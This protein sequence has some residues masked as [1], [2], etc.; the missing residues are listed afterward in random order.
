MNPVSVQNATHTHPEVAMWQWAQESRAWERT[1][2]L[3]ATHAASTD[4]KGKSN[5]NESDAAADC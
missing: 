5:Y 3:T 2:L 1:D 4:D